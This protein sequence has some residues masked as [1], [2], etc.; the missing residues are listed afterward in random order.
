MFIV[1][2]VNVCIHCIGYCLIVWAFGVTNIVHVNMPHKVLFMLDIQCVTC[3]NAPPSH[4]P[5]HTPLLVALVSCCCQWQELAVLSIPVTSFDCRPRIQSS[6]CCQ[7]PAPPP[8]SCPPP[9]D[10]ALKLP[11]VTSV[12]QM[13]LLAATALLHGPIKIITKCFASNCSLAGSN[14]NHNK[15]FRLQLLSCR[16]QSKS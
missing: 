10:R 2:K 13:A 4:P 8:D 3:K 5:P 1:A 14:Q 9:P 15:M 11:S 12:P 7:S 16:V 6:F